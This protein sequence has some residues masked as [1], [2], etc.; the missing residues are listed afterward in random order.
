MRRSDASGFSQGW[1][2]PDLRQPRGRVFEGRLSATPGTDVTTADVTAGTT[3]SYTESEGNLISLPWKPGKWEAFELP[4]TPAGVY[5]ITK[6]FIA[7]SPWAIASGS[8]YDVFGFLG[9][10]GPDLELGPAWSSDTARSAAGALTRRNGVRV[11]ARDQS[12]VFLGTIRASGANTIEDSAAKRFLWNMYNR[13]LRHLFRTSTTTSW[14][15]GNTNVWRQANAEAANEVYY[16]VGL[17]DR[18]VTARAVHSVLNSANSLIEA[19]AGIGIDSTTTNSAQQGASGASGISSGGQ[20]YLPCLAWYRGF[21][22]LGYHRLVWIERG[23]S[24]AQHTYSN[25][26]L[27]GNPGGI[28]AEIMA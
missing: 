26:G 6:T 8:N 27:A 28:S 17:D 25:G 11:L 10:N 15:Q 18:P 3:L 20:M 4:R 23:N 19:A 16:V 22:G 9:P 14:A 13:K 12:R 24:V 5:E 7:S 1:F 21:P 2:P